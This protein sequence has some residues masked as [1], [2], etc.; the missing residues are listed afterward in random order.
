MWELNCPWDVS[1]L[2]HFSGYISAQNGEGGEP[3]VTEFPALRMC[4]K[5]SHSLLSVHFYDCKLPVH[6]LGGA[7]TTTNASTMAIPPVFC[8]KDLLFHF[9]R[10]CVAPKR[11]KSLNW[12]NSHFSRRH[13]KQSEMKKRNEKWRRSRQRS[14]LFF[15]IHPKLILPHSSVASKPHKCHLTPVSSHTWKAFEFVFQTFQQKAA[16]VMNE[17]LLFVSQCPFRKL[18]HGTQLLSPS[19][20]FPWEGSV[21]YR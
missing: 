2:Q 9:C 1:S 14:E 11:I 12:W 18:R 15:H 7:E 21:I 10:F 4:W 16:S 17:H 8:G 5:Y 3:Q 6:S 19:L 13:H 20:S